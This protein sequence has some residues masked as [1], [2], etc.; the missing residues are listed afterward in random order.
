MDE[1]EYE[2]HDPETNDEADGVVAGGIAHHY[3]TRCSRCGV[4]LQAEMDEDG[5][6]VFWEVDE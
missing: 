3:V 1:C 4:R 6:L 5:V 2:G